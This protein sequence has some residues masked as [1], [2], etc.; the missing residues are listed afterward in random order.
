M[1]GVCWIVA[2]GE[3]SDDLWRGG[4]AGVSMWPMWLLDGEEKKDTDLVRFSCKKII[5]SA[6]FLKCFYTIII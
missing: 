5:V 3:E 4:H 2:A 6:Y 1:S